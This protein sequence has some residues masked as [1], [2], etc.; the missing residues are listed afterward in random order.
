MAS[1]THTRIDPARRVGH[2]GGRGTCSRENFVSAWAHDEL[3]GPCACARAPQGTLQKAQMEQATLQRERS[4][5]EAQDNANFEAAMAVRGAPCSYQPWTLACAGNAPGSVRGMAGI[6][7]D[8][9]AHHWPG[10]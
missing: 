4:K 5:Q 8:A 3:R 2:L 9:R 1:A 10:R 6:A 7:N